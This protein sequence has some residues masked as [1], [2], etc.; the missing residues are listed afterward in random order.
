MKGIKSYLLL[1]VVE[2][3]ERK[4][5]GCPSN[6]LCINWYQGIG[7]VKE[8]Y[9]SLRGTQAQDEAWEMRKLISAV[10][11]SIELNLSE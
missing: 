8:G 7:I 1:E 2:L 6:N 9:G 3:K 4:S 10:S 11:T 5:G